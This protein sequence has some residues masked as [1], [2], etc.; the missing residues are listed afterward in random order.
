MDI[1][2]YIYI[3]LYGSCQP[4]NPPPRGLG[5]SRRG[6]FFGK[7]HAPGSLEH[8]CCHL[9]AILGPPGKFFKIWS[10]CSNDYASKTRIKIMCKKT[11]CIAPH[12]FSQPYL[13]CNSWKSRTLAR[14]E[15]I[16]YQVK[17]YPRSIGITKC[18]V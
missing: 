11:C 2:I 4:T 6:L 18:H 12:L 7:K 5:S 16:K 14:M 8:V 10:I 13:L 3:W 15:L 9:L 17:K 1:Y